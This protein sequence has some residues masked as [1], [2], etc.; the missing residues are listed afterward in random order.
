MTITNNKWLEFEVVGP[1][2][3]QKYRTNADASLVQ[4]WSDNKVSGIA[5]F[6]W[7]T[8]KF[9][10]ASTRAKNALKAAQALGTVE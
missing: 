4:F 1:V 9:L 2:E 3:T 6:G 10:N 7:N 8:T 5:K